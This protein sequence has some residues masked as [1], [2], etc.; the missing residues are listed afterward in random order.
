[1]SKPLLVISCPADTHSGYGARARD[2]IWALQKYDKFE[3]KTLSQR[4]GSTPFGFLKP[5]VPEHKAILDTFLDNGQLPRKP[6]VWIQLTVPNE[7][8]QVGEYN[9][10][11]T[12]G[13]ETTI[14]D[15]SWIEGVNRMNLVL[16]SSKHA[17]TV[18]ESTVAHQKDGNG[19]VVKEIK[20][21]TPIEVLF[22][23][24][25]LNKYF[26]MEDAD[27]PENDVVEALDNIDE[28]FN[29]LFVG[30]WLQGELGEDRKNVGMLIKSFLE[31]FKNKKNKPGL[32]LKTNSAATSI[33]D[34]EETLRKINDVRN[35]VKGD[36]PN[37]YLLHGELED[38]EMNYL[39]NH[40][41]VKAM[42]SLTKGEGFGRPL[43]E[44]TLSKKP[45]IASG[46][47]GHTDFLDPEFSILVSGELKPI[48]H[49]AVVQNMLLAESY[50]FTPNYEQVGAILTD[51]YA[52]YDKYI[53]RAKRQAHKSKTDFNFDKMA[54]LLDVIFET[55]IPK[56]VEL[57][58][59]TLRK[60]EIPKL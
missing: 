3:I 53:P 38:E 27:I 51:M 42:I 28:N 2:L 36:L 21:T 40:P 18:F 14:C 10:G 29:F 35:T 9:I 50:W 8:Q 12:A 47:S 41:K 48:H 56:R 54:E 59:P 19:N 4:W 5:E 6:D 23:G 58:M 52:N 20:A 57:K 45:I 13:I 60:L 11:I 39:Y 49:S 1:M 33:M 26:H 15:P 55:R 16:V 37:I 46:W 31:T 32:I 7:F 17:K 43:L 22:E 44:F 24:A 34:R 30:H 25:D